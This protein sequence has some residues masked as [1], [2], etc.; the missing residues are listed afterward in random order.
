MN[1]HCKTTD[2]KLS[3]NSLAIRFGDDSTCSSPDPAPPPQIHKQYPSYQQPHHHTT[4]VSTTAM[5]SFSENHPNNSISNT[6]DRISITRA[7]YDLLVQREHMYDEAVQKRTDMRYEMEASALDIEKTTLQCRIEMESL[8]LAA[9]AKT[10]QHHHSK[11]ESYFD[12]PYDT[13]HLL[14]MKKQMQQLMGVRERIMINRQSSE[15]MATHC[16]KRE[17][18][19]PISSDAF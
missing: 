16:G 18:C 6:K 15:L 10:I 1:R 4:A 2:T 5:T 17:H 12:A 19:N 7:V 14:S 9:Q 8:Q 13:Q 11:T 3:N